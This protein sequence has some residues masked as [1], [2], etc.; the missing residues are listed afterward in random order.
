M[1]QSDDVPVPM[2]LALRLA[3][4]SLYY[5]YAGPSDEPSLTILPGALPDDLPLRIPMPPGGRLL[6]SVVSVAPSF[7][8]VS[9]GGG[10]PR[11][12][13]RGGDL[14]TVYLD[15]PGG[16]ER[17]LASFEQ[18]MA[19]QGWRPPAI[20]PDSVMR[21]RM[22][23]GGGGFQ[24]TG[25]PFYVP[26]SRT[27][28][29]SERGPSLRVVVNLRDAGPQDVRL[30]L[31]LFDTGQCAESADD[32]DDAY[33]PQFRITRM[34]PV[35]QPPMGVEMWG[36]GGGGSDQ[37]WHTDA[38]A[39]TDMDAAALVAHFGGQFRAAGWTQRDEGVNGALA[40]SRWTS[41]DGRYEADLWVI[42]A[43]EPGERYLRLRAQ[44]AEPGSSH[45][46]GFVTFH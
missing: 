33:M 21:R 40:W 35:L 46:A 28:C 45:G 18:P 19:E 3:Q 43:P 25:A 38:T 44:R 8:A 12:R 32:D 4:G 30:Y 36:G 9:F 31:S 7:I 39:H 15:V 29:A 2:A 6:G 37:D 13:P 22:G 1:Q 24:S 10:R 34:L 27:F 11:P 26:P 14:V 23:R 20:D 17:I 5:G 42:E 41:E 16:A